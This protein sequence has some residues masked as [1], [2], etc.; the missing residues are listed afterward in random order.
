MAQ[1]RSPFQG[2]RNIIRFNW[3]F[4]VLAAVFLLLLI[5]LATYLPAE[6]GRYIYMLC[7][8]SVAIT[9]IS[10]LVSYYVY[11]LSGLYA[12]EWLDKSREDEAIKIVTINAGFDETSAIIQGAFKQAELQTLDFYD[13]DK[14][15]E[16]SIKRARKAYPPHPNTL[17]VKTSALPLPDASVDKVFAI[18][19]AHEIR[20]EQERNIFFQEL[21]RILRDDGEIIV[22][23]HLRDTAN[24]LAYNIGFFHFHSKRSWLNTF[25][26][27][28][29]TVKKEFRITP[30]ITTFIL[31][32]NGTT[33]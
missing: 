5:I 25:A 8:I 16:V 29:L 12:F 14:H 30:F 21:S 9:V 15:T 2:V 26:A 32:K 33:S 10:L 19:A 17:Q 24:F 7:L 4:Y 31:K 13:P 20:Q 28:R 27:A 1:I 3:H 23:E 6:I 22:T 11:D 18:L